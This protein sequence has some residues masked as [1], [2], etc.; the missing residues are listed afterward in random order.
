[1]SKVKLLYE[2]G[3]LGRDAIHIVGGKAAH[4]GALIKKNIPIPEGFVLSTSSFERFLNRSPFLHKIRE[5]LDKEI[6]LTEITQTS[7]QLQNYILESEFPSDLKQPIVKRYQELKEQDTSIL[8]AVRSSA[9]VEDLSK[10][11]FAGQADTFLCISTPEELIN[12]IKKCW[13]SL[14]SSRALMYIQ[15][16]I[17]VPFNLVSM[18][19]VIQKMVRSEVSGVMFT[20]N[21]LNKDRNQVLINATCGFG[22]CIADG[23]VEPDSIT[24]DKTT[25]KIIKTRIGTK[26]KM[27]IKNPEMDGTILIDTP[28]KQQQILCL[29]EGQI[30]DLVQYGIEIENLFDDAPQ[31]IEWAIEDG[32]IKILQARNITHL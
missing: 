18:G 19:V 31:D 12:S 15:Q 24:V 10:T 20:A 25:F 7:K 29:T 22:E 30:R 32:Q 11:S 1:M 21:V 28:M 9:N 13:A 27:S 4:L 3:A 2:L 23:K 6:P 26:V 8:V 16:M 14:Y 17:K 5:L